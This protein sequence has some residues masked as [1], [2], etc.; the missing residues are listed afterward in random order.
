MS[1]W[2]L[3]GELVCSGF[4]AI[5]PWREAD[6]KT[7]LGLTLAVRSLSVSAEWCRDVCPTCLE[8]CV[9]NEVFA[10]GDIIL[11]A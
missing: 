8:S 9:G 4:P 1:P 7:V 10:E 6:V 3:Q 5:L 11:F 2:R